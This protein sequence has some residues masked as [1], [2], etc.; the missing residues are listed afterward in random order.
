MNLEPSR[1]TIEAKECEEP[2]STWV[3]GVAAGLYNNFMDIPH[4]VRIKPKISYD[5][6]FS[7]VAD[8]DGTF[9]SCDPNK[10]VIII[11]P[12]QSDANKQKT[13]LHELSHCLS[14]EY[15]LN[16]TEKQ[17]QG[18]EKALYSFLKLNKLD[19]K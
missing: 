16:L 12:N 13:W 11:S 6:F 19:I 4:R 5:V 8:I 18:L 3:A 15:D 10:R 17:V 7:E 9:G 14:F 2:L 1:K